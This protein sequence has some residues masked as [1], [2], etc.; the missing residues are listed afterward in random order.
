MAVAVKKTSPVAGCLFAFFV[1]LAP[2][3]LQTGKGTNERYKISLQHRG[4]APR[5]GQSPFMLSLRLVR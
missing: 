5:W 4:I 2:V 3:T 1:V